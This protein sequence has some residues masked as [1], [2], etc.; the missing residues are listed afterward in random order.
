MILIEFG[1]N[2]KKRLSEDRK[3]KLHKMIS[4]ANNLTDYIVCLTVETTASPNN[5]RRLFCQ[6]VE[7][8][9]SKETGG[10]MR[11]TAPYIGDLHAFLKVNSPV[12]PHIVEIEWQIC[13]VREP[14]KVV[15]AESIIVN[16]GVPITETTTSLT[17]LTQARVQEE[18]V[19]FS[20]ALQRVSKRPKSSSIT[21]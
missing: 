9:L 18:G 21:I 6:S 17:K 11:E 19:T 13:S 5:L 2:K 7:D 16:P 10:A 15:D 4:M 8:R 20:E 14:F 3:N 1:L 12:I